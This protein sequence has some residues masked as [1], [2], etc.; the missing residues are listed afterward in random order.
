MTYDKI[1]A[2]VVL[3][4]YYVISSG[5]I[6][7]LSEY[8][9]ACLNPHHNRQCYQSL[10]WFGVI[11]VTIFFGIILLPYVPF[12]WFYKLMTVKRKDK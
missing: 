4:I 5:V 11:V 2:L 7:F 6:V 3:I 10:N 9:F 12:Y 8:G 1:L